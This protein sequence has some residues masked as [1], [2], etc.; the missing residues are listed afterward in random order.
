MK[1]PDLLH[2]VPTLVGHRPMVVCTTLESHEG[3]THLH[4]YYKTGNTYVVPCGEAE[5]AEPYGY[6]G[7]HDATYVLAWYLRGQ[8]THDDLDVD[9]ADL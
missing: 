9:P 1:E 8:F 2:D 7:Y 5:N 4:I 6:R 3:A